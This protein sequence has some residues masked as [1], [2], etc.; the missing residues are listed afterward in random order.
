MMQ[1]LAA[2]APHAGRLRGVFFD[3]DDTLTVSG[4]LVP[5]AFAALCALR[6]AGLRLVPVTGRPAGF[7]EVL[8]TY[9]PVDAAVAENGGV[10]FVRRGGVLE[11]RYYEG[12]SDR[13]AAAP[14]LHA[15]RA[16]VVARVPRARPTD[17]AWLRLTDLAFDIGET[18]TLAEAEIAAIVARIRAAG[19][20]ALVSTIHAHAFFG[21]YDKAK[22][23]ARL[24]TEL[25]G[26]DPEKSRGDYLFV[27]DSPNDQACFA[28]FPLSAGVAN[29]ARFA[30]ELRPPPAFV[31][32]RAGGHGFAEIADLLL[33]ERN[34]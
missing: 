24:M 28:W 2:L 32:T 15:L 23:C 20:T 33:S 7:G 19:A 29:V 4:T 27:G 5:D 13:S 25:W 11:P 1:P 9:F 8:A 26:E 3:I 18:Q 21:S 34:S 16:D 12:E 31:A 22:M 6:A 17:D 10:A 30:S 14:R